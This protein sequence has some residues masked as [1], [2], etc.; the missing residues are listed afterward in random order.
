MTDEPYPQRQHPSHPAPVVRFNESV[1]V[2]VNVCTKDR[3]PVLACEA[4]HRLCREIWQAADFWHVGQYVIMP[5]HIHLFC[6]PG[7]QPMPSLKQWVEYWKGQV[8]ARWPMTAELRDSS[9]ESDD[10]EVV[11]P[12]NRNGTS[13]GTEPVPPGNRYGGPTSVSAVGTPIKLWQRDFWD[14]QMRSLEHYEEKLSYVRMNPI[15]KEL[16]KD[17]EVW[18]YQGEVFPISWA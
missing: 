6:S 18:P 14:T 17:V 11:P 12:K 13:D 1:I 7:R 2:Q 15:R 5:D 4:V 16:A 3:R 8:A 9:T 10:T